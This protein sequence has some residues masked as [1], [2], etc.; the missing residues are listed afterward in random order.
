MQCRNGGDTL[1]TG[2]SL[3]QM[4]CGKRGCTLSPLLYLV[5]TNV[6]VSREPDVIMSAWDKGYMSYAYISGVQ[7][8]EGIDQGEWMVYLL[9]DDTAFVAENPAT[10][11]KLLRGRADQLG[12]TTSVHTGQHMA[13][14]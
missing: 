11:G 1:A 14:S 13:A 8:L 10:M 5:V 9:C 12:Q 6:R 2:L 7:N 4:D 3:Q